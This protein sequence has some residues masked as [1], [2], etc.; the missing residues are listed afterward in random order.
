MAQRDDQL[1]EN[2]EK[3]TTG[4]TQAQDEYDR[5][6]AELESNYQG[7]LTAGPWSGY[8]APNI[9]YYDVE[10]LNMVAREHSYV[11]LGQHR[12]ALVDQLRG[13]YAIS[14]VNRTG[15]YLEVGGYSGHMFDR[16]GATSMSDLMRYT[17]NYVDTN[18]RDTLRSID[19]TG[20]LEGEYNKFVK[21]AELGGAFA[22]GLKT[23]A[24]ALNNAAGDSFV[25]IVSVG[26]LTGED[27]GWYWAPTDVDIAYGYYSSYAIMR[28]STELL[29]GV[30]LGMA[31]KAPGYTA[32]GAFALDAAG[33]FSGT[34]QGV[35]SMTQEG[36]NY[37]NAT[38]TAF[39]LA[40]VGGNL[41]GLTRSAPDRIDIGDFDDFVAPRR[42]ML[43]VLEAR[44]FKII[45]S[46]PIQIPGNAGIR[47]RTSGSGAIEARYTW[48][49]SAGQKFVA[50]FHDPSPG[51]PSGSLPSWVVERITPGNSTGTRRVTEIFLGDDIWI[52]QG[53]WYR[54][55]DAYQNGTAT[56]GILNI[57]RRGHFPIE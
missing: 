41:G 38:Q 32:K 26:F 33:N 47:F 39:G 43:E 13:N 24:K 35:Y 27:V 31:A 8:Q 34:G 12:V 57:L 55:I 17:G 5:R 51:A 30:G 20:L 9:S 18:I 11:S 45:E 29:S 28:F 14:E 36:V 16:I 15:S 1:D 21:T 10:T 49:N 53:I 40:G 44:K 56:D 3:Q 25:G 4:L 48:N 37:A 23:G 6:V 2:N 50:R 19:S 42:T 7:N 46:S 52:K 54:N 22:E